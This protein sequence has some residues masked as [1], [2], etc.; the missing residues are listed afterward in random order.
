MEIHDIKASAQPQ[1]EIV[2]NDVAI[3]ERTTRPMYPSAG[4]VASRTTVPCVLSVSV[5]GSVLLLFLWNTG[6]TL[7]PMTP[8]SSR[9]ETTP[10][11]VRA[12]LIAPPAEFEPQGH[13]QPHHSYGNS[14]DM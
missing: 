3:G 14:A 2:E 11:S 7:S 12:E 9:S 5:S 4:L 8:R 13:R 6:I 10:R 1:E